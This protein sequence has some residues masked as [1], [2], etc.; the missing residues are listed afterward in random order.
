MIFTAW[1][2]IILVVLTA[3]FLIISRSSLSNPGSHGFY[4]FIAWELI[5]LLLLLN[6]TYWFEHPFSWFQVI[7]WLFLILS[8]VPLI[9]G[10]ILLSKL[11]KRVA[12]RQ[13]DRA[14]LPF[15][16]T[17]TLVKVGIF[18]YIRHPL[19][20]SLLLL[21]WGTFLKHPSWLAS[22]LALLASLFLFLTALAEEK[23][24]LKYFGIEYQVYMKE[25]KRFI[26]FVF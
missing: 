22:I 13:D 1:K 25:T 7:S 10:V 5:L 3:I 9:L 6:V 24:M 8:L 4:R 17:S 19:Y 11:G 20:A 23:E 21:T 2:L 14:L 16:K 12:T 26:P 18:R 15:E